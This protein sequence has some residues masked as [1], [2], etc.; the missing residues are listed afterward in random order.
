LEEV[1]EALELEPLLHLPVRE[2]SL[3]QRTRCELAAVLLHNPSVL[4]LDEPTIGL[5]IEVKL[6][7]RAFLKEINAKHK[8]TILVA[9]HDLQDVEGF[10]DRVVVIDKGRIIFD[11]SLE[12]LRLDYSPYFKRIVLHFK[13]E[14]ALSQAQHQLRR[15]EISLQAT[16]QSIDGLSVTVTLKQEF[17]IQSILET[18]PQEDLKDLVVEDPRIEDV[19]LEIYRRQDEIPLLPSDPV[20]KL[21]R[22]AN[23]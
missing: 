15:L 13:D 1:V 2:L 4:L 9:S 17:K 14:E 5:D 12:K 18:I 20:V 19:V 7:V 22:S 16:R 10:A 3:G 8:I 11:G 23:V 6:K 21:E